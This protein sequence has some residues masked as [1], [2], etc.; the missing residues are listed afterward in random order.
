MCMG[1]FYLIVYF[2]DPLIFA[3]H[4]YHLSYIFV[5]QFGNVITF[6]LI[7]NMLIKPFTGVTKEAKLVTANKT[8]LQQQ[9]SNTNEFLYDPKLERDIGVLTVKYLQRAAIF[10]ILAN[11]PVTIYF[12]L[13]GMPET[14]E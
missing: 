11:F 2:M 14:A 12:F 5:R 4:F 9:V 8:L 7:L 3:F 1:L 13:Y 10:D 6:L